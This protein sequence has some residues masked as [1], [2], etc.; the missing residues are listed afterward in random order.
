V[1]NGQYRRFVEAGGYDER[2]YWTEAGWAWRT[3]VYDSKVPKWLVSERPPEKR[4]RPFWWDDPARNLPNLPVV[5]ICWFEA[6]AYTRW[7]SDVTGCP[8][9][10]PAEAEWEKAARGTDGRIYPWGNGEI[11][12]Q[13]ANYR[14]TGIG[15]TSPVGCFPS[16]ASPHGCMDMVGNVWE[17][18]CSLYRS[19]PYDPG[20]GREDLEAEGEP[21]LR[22]GSWRD[23]QSHARCA[24]RFWNVA[25]SWN[26]YMGFR[27]ARGSP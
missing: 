21:V 5:G 27:C 25:G 4:D 26:D 15:S 6:L 17:W 10:L 24:F 12:P 11:R 8:C 7:L 22:G 19:Y 3:I 14:E 2:R 9:R 20:D 1:T 18:C 23:G 16:G 13:R